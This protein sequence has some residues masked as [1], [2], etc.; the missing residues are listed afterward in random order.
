[1]ATMGTESTDGERKGMAMRLRTKPWRDVLQ[2]RAERRARVIKAEDIVGAYQQGKR[3][4]AA[5][6]SI[7][8]TRYRDPKLDEAWMRGQVDAMR[9]KRAGS[10]R[11]R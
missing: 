1:M 2:E 5:G 6:R 8:A 3:D 10:V 11:G 9:A 7:N 4:F